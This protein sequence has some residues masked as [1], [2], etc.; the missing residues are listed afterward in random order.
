[1]QIT[2]K[3]YH[4]GAESLLFSPDIHCVICV[5]KKGY[6]NEMKVIRSR[7]FMYTQDLDHLP[8][9]KDTLK[10]RLEKSGAQE[11]AFILHDKD[12]DE[13]NKKIRPHFHVM[14][15]FKDAKTI[16]RISKIFNDK[17]QYIEVWKNSINN[18]YSY[19]IHETSKAKNKYHYKDSEVVA[20]FDFKSKINSIRRKINKPSKQAVDNYIEDY[21]NEIISKEDLQN[22]IGVLEMA[23]HKNL[24]DHIE[25]IL[26]FKKHQKFLKE[27]KG[28]QCKVIWLYGK[29]G[30]GKTRLI[31]NFLEHYYPNNFIILGSQR[32]H[33]QEYKGQNYI[34]I[35]DLRPND[36]EYGQLL[37]LL[38]PWEND[39]MAP[40][41]YHDKYLNA[42]AIFIT[43]PYSPKDFY[44][45]CN[46][47]NI[48]IDSFDQLKRRIISFHIT[49]NNL[50]Q[51]S[52]DITTELNLKN[53][54]KRTKEKNNGS[55]IN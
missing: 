27:F 31:R 38:D 24:L 7:N 47:E 39:K 6:K 22:N 11:W 50:S 49:E 41:R 34:V 44:N 43:T 16:S 30:V 29:A 17:Q 40:A 55:T 23:K 35:N 42:K 5:K 46:I 32:D 54:S 3:R 8:F 20:S 51:L 26:A 1:M 21:A 18:G 10:T 4:V 19:L 12:V 14:L 15:R 25:D 13:N 9:N 48:F 45:T 37:T 52:Q 53:K 33:F 28:K 2:L 36:Y